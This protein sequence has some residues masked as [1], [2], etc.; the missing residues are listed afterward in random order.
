MD[1][2]ASIPTIVGNRRVFVVSDERCGG[3][4]FGDILRTLSQRSHL[5]DPW[6]P[7]TRADIGANSPTDAV[8][9]AFAVNYSL[10]YSLC[11]HDLDM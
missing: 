7:A 1:S 11:L 2:V 8:D 5:D 10:K 4:S 9:K 3:N 6:A